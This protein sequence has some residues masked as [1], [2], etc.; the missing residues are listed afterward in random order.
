L[1]AIN[2]YFFNAHHSP[3]G[4]FSSFTLGYPGSKGGLGLELAKPADQNVYIGLQSR[5][6]KYYEAL[7][8]YDPNAED[9]AARKSL[10]KNSKKISIVQFTENNIEREFKLGTDTWRAGDLEFKIFSPVI[11][12]PDP[13]ISDEQD[14]M[15]ALLPA[16]L[17][18]ITVD[19]TKSKSK[20]RLFFGYKGNDPYSAMRLLKNTTNEQCEGIAQGR[21]TAIAAN[22]GRMFSGLGYNIES[23]LSREIKENF[24]FGLGMCGLVMADIEPECKESFRLAVCFYRGGK[25]TT[26][27]E[28]SYY[29]TNFYKS[30]EEVAMFSLKH[31]EDLVESWAK[32]NN[33]FDGYNLSREQKFMICQ[34]IRSYY[35]NTQLM[36]YDGR[37]FWVVNEGEY[38]MMNTLDLTVDQLF[39]ELIMN[40]W[41]VRNELDMFMEHYSYKDEIKFPNDDKVY[42][43]GLS[44]THDMGVCNAFSKSGFSTYEMF[45]KDDCF[46][47]MTQEMLL[48]WLCCACVYIE[49]TN[50]K[51]WSD[52]NINIFKECFQSMLNRDNPDKAK[53]NGIMGLDSTRTM[54]GAEI[55]T[56]DAVDVSLGQARDNVYIASKCW[57]VYVML[58]KLFSNYELHNLE[59][60]S[61]QQA[62]KCSETIIK[63]VT[64]EGYL[65]AFIDSSNNSKI[66]PAI[67]GIVFPYFAGCK[68]YLDKNGRFKEYIKV[69][70]RHIRTILV[71]GDCL[72]ENGAWKLSS[73]SENSWLSKIY[74]CQFITRHI[75][76]IKDDESNVADKAHYDWLIDP[77][78]SYWC[79]SD[80]IISGI[81]SESKYYP[82]GVTSI[83][84]LYESLHE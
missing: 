24:S 12:I 61:L 63:S 56:Y 32:S 52:K 48:N 21:I 79:W 53:R 26:G 18:E 46:S 33:M 35:G 82:R 68:E 75:L 7:P 30:I 66:I 41:T 10:E 13:T 4:A 64:K 54:N 29:Y 80:Q 59:Q 73:N 47:H 22:S 6:G 42:N 16:V 25:V 5:D 39:F 38:R 15:M 20:R 60:E 72:F 1:I 11:S 3:I 78:N 37:P 57:A 83:L 55:T 43:G 58:A 69:L 36:D 81:A 45:G 65:P 19:N 44:F 76:G 40:P 9:G 28:T 8:F 17:V 27:L 50:D 14:L 67:E 23:I 70:E 2:N 74:L 49:W 77:R 84:W 51:V 62:E 71:K 31:Y 34:A